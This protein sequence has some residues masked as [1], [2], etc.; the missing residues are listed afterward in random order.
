LFLYRKIHGSGLW[1]TEPWLALGPWWT[2]DRGA[3]RPLQSSGGRRGSSDRDI[4]IERERGGRR[5]RRS[6]RFS[7]MAPLGGRATEMTTRRRSIE[8]VGGAPMGRWFRV[9]GGD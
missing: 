4:Y 3:A 5:A 8:A 7:L 6:M 9:R 1:I 2:R